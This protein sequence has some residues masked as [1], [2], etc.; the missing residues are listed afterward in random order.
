V[1]AADEPVELTIA[2]GKEI[3]TIRGQFDAQRLTE[4]S[5]QNTTNSPARVGIRARAMAGDHELAAGLVQYV[6]EQNVYVAF[7]RR[8]TPDKL[9]DRK[10]AYPFHAVFV[11]F[12]T[13]GAW[14]LLWART[15]KRPAARRSC[16]ETMNRLF[17]RGGA[18]LVFGLLIG[19]VVWESYRLLDAATEIDDCRQQQRYQREREEVLLLLLTERTRPQIDKADLT[20]LLRDRFGADFPIF[21]ISPTRLEVGGGLVFTLDGEQVT[22]ILPVERNPWEA[23]IGFA[24]RIITKPKAQSRDPKSL[25]PKA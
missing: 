22:G 13:F 9:E 1:F 4:Y 14:R 6:T 16:E 23:S 17:V 2:A 5:W 19:L 8:G 7:G 3:K 25:E 24:N 15:T 20:Q 11:G 18:V 12:I 10:G 21:L